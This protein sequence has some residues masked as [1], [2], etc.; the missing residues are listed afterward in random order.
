MYRRNPC[1]SLH[2][3]R[4]LGAS[5]STSRC[6]ETKSSN[7]LSCSLDMVCTSSILTGTRILALTW[8]RPSEFEASEDGYLHFDEDVKCTCECGNGLEDNS[9]VVRFETLYTFFI[10]TFSNILYHSCFHYNIL[11]MTMEAVIMS[12]YASLFDLTQPPCREQT[13]QCQHKPP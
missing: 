5:N 3:D 8:S 1:M 9:F 2:L 12:L 13:L 10:V 11:C 6:K 4:Y 7:R